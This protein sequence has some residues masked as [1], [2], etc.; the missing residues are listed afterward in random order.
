MTRTPRLI[1]RILLTEEQGREISDGGELVVPQVQFRAHCR[2]PAHLG[3]FLWCQEPYH[4]W[5]PSRW[6]SQRMHGIQAG[7][8]F[9]RRTPDHI[10]G[11]ECR[12]VYHTD[13]SRL[14]R[15]FSRATLEIRGFDTAARTITCRVHLVPVDELLTARRAGGGGRRAA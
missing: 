15:A 1:G 9:R 4:E 14:P 7:P 3:D 13:G 8:R 6:G 12:Y 5:S 2:Q 11:N 10:K